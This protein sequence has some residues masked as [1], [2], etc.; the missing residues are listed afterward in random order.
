MKAYYDLMDQCKD[1][2]DWQ[3]KLQKELGSQISFLA[4]TIDEDS[5]AAFVDFSP[6]F[7]RYDDEKQIY[8]K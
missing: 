6:I 1:F 8:F 7:K 4:K 3:R 5:H 2:P